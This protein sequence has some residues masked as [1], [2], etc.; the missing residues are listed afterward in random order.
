MREVCL[1]VLRHFFVSIAPRHYT[2]GITKLYE[3]LS[4]PRSQAAIEKIEAYIGSLNSYNK[5]EHVE[6]SSA[7]KTL[8]A[9]SGEKAF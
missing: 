2:G 6:L 3:A 7:K 5:N 9:K 1:L 4:W 8:I